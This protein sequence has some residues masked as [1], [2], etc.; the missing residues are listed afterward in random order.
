MIF[1]IDAM[2]PNY[3]ASL[4]CDT[5]ADITDLEDYTKKHHLAAG[6]TCIVKTTGDVY[7]QDSTGAWGKLG[8]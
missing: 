6:S 3:T 7:M 4:G 1:P 2:K 5:E 8:G